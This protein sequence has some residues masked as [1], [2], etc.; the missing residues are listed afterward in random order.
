MVS[1]KRPTAKLVHIARPEEN[2][3]ICYKLVR[4]LIQTDELIPRRVRPRIHSSKIRGKDDCSERALPIPLLYSFL[5]TVPPVKTVLIN[6][7]QMK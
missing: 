3:P 2:K 1:T 4:S 5:E 6:R 7:I